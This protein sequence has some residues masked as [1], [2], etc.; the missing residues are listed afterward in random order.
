MASA[1][2]LVAVVEVRGGQGMQKRLFNMGLRPGIELRV[3]NSGHPGP[4]LV[5]VQD[6]RVAL[7][8][9]M[10]HRVIVVPKDDE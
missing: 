9:G 1:G 4:F 5:A 2:E 8:H 10:A 3:L 6:T 7:G